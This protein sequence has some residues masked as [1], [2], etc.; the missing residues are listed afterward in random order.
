[1]IVDSHAHVFPPT[2]IDRRAS[3]LASFGTDP[4]VEGDDL[5]VKGVKSLRGAAVRWV[6]RATSTKPPSTTAP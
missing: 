2:V 5:V 1:M 6:S 4:K 3:L